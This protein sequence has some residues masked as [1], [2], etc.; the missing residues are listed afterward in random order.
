MFGFSKHIGNDNPLSTIISF[1]R[2]PPK[3]KGQLA[4]LNAIADN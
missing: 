3:Q 4:A 2:T 1:T